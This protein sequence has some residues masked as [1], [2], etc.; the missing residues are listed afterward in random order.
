MSD[1]THYSTKTFTGLPCAHRQWRDT[2]HCRFIHGY[3]RTVI[4]TFACEKL[5]EK[6]WVVD[7]G[8]LKDVR[9]WLEELMDH[10]LLINADDPE[11]PLFREMHERGIVDLRI[12]PSVGMEGTARYV[13]EHVDTMIREKTGDRCRVV[14]VECRENMKNSGICE[15][16]E[17][18]PS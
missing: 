18:R 4:F 1:F 8:N 14:R 16:R 17:E 5:D 12:L 7:F 11:L 13:F 9:A 15:R 10:T 6:G 3:E 2:G